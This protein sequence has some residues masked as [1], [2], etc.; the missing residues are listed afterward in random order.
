MVTRA[1][2]KVEDVF[3]NMP[4]FDSERLLLERMTLA[5]AADMHAYTG[6][7][8]MVE[9]LPL[10]A[11]KSVDEARQAIQGFMDM[12]LSR[13]VSPWGIRLKE[14][15]QHIGICG[16]EGW[17]AATD[18]AEIGFI[19]GRE[20]WRHGYATE[21][22]KRVMRF[23]FEHMNLNR[24][25]ARC[26]VDNVGSQLLLEHKLGMRFEGL[27]REHSYW[28]G[29]YHDLKLYSLLRREFEG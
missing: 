28:K 27:L 4:E 5:D 7:P 22:A 18:R 2:I 9:Q 1:N 10:N 17:N 3:G 6:D 25:E 24:L 15:G 19:V 11:T 23:G 16:F 20:H 21:A 14:T 8:A 26:T 12:Y 29:Q 13:R